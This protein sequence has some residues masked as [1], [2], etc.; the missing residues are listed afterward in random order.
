LT[1]IGRA[2]TCG[3]VY[4]EQGLAQQPYSVGLAYQPMLGRALL[5]GLLDYLQNGLAWKEIAAGMLRP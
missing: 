3:E 5:P 4:Y 2:K 1:K